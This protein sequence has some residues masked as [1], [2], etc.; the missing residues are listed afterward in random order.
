MLSRKALTRFTI[1]WVILLVAFSLQPT[2]VPGTRGRNIQHESGHVVIFGA[3]AM[4]MLALARNREEEWKAAAATLGLAV[5]IEIAQFLIYSLPNF[6]WWDVREDLIGIAIAMIV[7]R[8]TRVR[9]LIL[10]DAAG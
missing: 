5:G 2:R 6:E 3:T 4:L 9:R 10:A 7:A 1:I 8:A